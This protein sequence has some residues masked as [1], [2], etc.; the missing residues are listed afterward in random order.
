[1]GGLPEKE[2]REELSAYGIETWAGDV[3]MVFSKE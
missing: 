3:G 2:V 1:V